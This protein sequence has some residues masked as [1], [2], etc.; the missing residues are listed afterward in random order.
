M[1]SS[2]G[3]DWARG[4]TEQVDFLNASMVQQGRDTHTAT[5]ARSEDPPDTEGIILVD[6]DRMDASD[7][8]AADE[9]AGHR[10]AY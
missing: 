2:A 3:S 10:I 8:D 1:E 5:H 4:V 7:V 9:A 6:E